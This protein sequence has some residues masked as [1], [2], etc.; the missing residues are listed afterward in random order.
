MNNSI[1]T[2]NISYF[3]LAC[4][5]LFPS[6]ILEKVGLSPGIAQIAVL[7][8]AKSAALDAF[9]SRDITFPLLGCERHLLCER[10][11]CFVSMVMQL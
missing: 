2:A 10:V 7:D 1:C 3:Q 9:I 8:L 11:H 4:P 5:V 6:D